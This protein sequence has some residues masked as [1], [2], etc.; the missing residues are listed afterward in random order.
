[1]L[2]SLK[3]FCKDKFSFQDTID[4]FGKQYRICVYYYQYSKKITE[5]QIKTYQN[6]LNQK[7][8][9]CADIENSIFD[10]YNKFIYDNVNEYD[11][12]DLNF[13]VNDICELKN[14]VKPLSIEIYDYSDDYT[15]S[16]VFDL[17]W[18]VERGIGVFLKNNK[19]DIV[20]SQSEVIK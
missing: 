3:C 9:V 7:D 1:M 2:L 11:Y 5:K 16:I 12:I 19:V 8:T 13:V 14:H 18:D 20:G 15:M 4:L 17:N 10:Y 6:F